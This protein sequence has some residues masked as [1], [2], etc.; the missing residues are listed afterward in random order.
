[1]S[2]LFKSLAIIAMIAG[3]LACGSREAPADAKPKNDANFGILQNAKRVETWHFQ[4]ISTASS[5]QTAQVA[6]AVEALYESYAEHF[7]I[8]DP[9]RKMELV[10]YKDQTEFRTYNRSSPWA[11]AYY[12]T[13]R[14]YAY[15]AS[16]DNPYHWM[17]HEATHQLL[18]E[19]SGYKPAK[20]A[21]EGIA[22]YFGAST[23][24]NEKL[25]R[26]HADSGAYPIW[27]L[28]SLRLTG[29]STR[30]IAS[31]AI[32]PL[33]ELITDTG[34]N[35]NEHVNLYYMH[36]WGLTHFLMHHSS[37]RYS[38]AYKQLIAQGGSLE[39]FESL[40]GPVESIQSEWYDYMH[41]QAYK[42]VPKASSGGP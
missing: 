13:P 21:N 17:L 8:K 23:L 11:E 28:P 19:A 6:S 33:R 38:N 4:I 36:Y 18:K 37:S 5:D 32:I 35:I 29:D 2:S 7:G 1:M 39:D 20:W 24:V 40:V 27:W 30:D 22:A 31:G 9:V 12:R 41:R 10:L 42:S 3:L 25:L 15:F 26:G 16:G 34:P 14:S